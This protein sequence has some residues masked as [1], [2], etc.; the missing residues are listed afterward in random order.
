MQQC[1]LRVSNALHPHPPTHPSPAQAKALFDF[2]SNQNELNDAKED[3]SVRDL[4]FGVVRR[5]SCYMVRRVR[6][7]YSLFADILCNEC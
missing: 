7:W 4:H 3:K 1:S 2:Q 6:R 5:D